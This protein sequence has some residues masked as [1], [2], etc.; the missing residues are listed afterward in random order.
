MRGFRAALAGA[1]I[2]LG[3]LATAS[4]VQA[5]ETFDFSYS[6]DGYTGGGSFVAT[7]VK[8]TYYLD[9]ISG[10]ANGETIT[11]LADYAGANGQLHFPKQPDVDQGGIS[12]ST[13]DDTFNLFTEKHHRS[14]EI[15]A[16]STDPNAWASLAK[17]VCLTITAVPEPATWAMMLVGFGGLGASL[18]TARRRRGA[19]LAAI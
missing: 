12:F 11:T 15:I 17:P 14:V 16:E 18:R 13:A 4:A 5:T 9:S 2:V 3:A 19:A 7:Y 10:A 8:G 1:T 6:G